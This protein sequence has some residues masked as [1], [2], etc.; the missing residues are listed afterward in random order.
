MDHRP[1]G[2]GRGGVRTDEPALTNRFAVAIWALS[3]AGVSACSGVVPKGPPEIRLGVDACSHCGMV[4]E[5]R[6]YAAAILANDGFESRQHIFDDIGC[7]ALWEA[8]V[9]GPAVRGRWVHDRTTAAW[10]D[11]S[12]ATF[13]VVS[14]LTTPMGS[15]VTAFSTR[16]DADAFVSEH[17]GEELSWD[18]LLARARDGSLTRRRDSRPQGAR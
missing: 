14:D 5:E 13:A 11:A 9:H 7:L 16:S 18:A 4:V 10:I 15:G 3:W 17:G 2:C 6:R 12:T 1:P 8:A